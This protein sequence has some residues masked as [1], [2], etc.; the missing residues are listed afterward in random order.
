MYLLL[1]KRILSRHLL[2]TCDLVKVKSHMWRLNDKVTRNHNFL[3]ATTYTDDNFTKMYTLSHWKTQDGYK[4]W[5]RS[6]E[7]KETYINGENLYDEEEHILL[8]PM[9][10]NNNIFLL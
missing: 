2:T 1:S 6:K 3:S 7:R 10:V 8:N 9:I 5:L 4:E